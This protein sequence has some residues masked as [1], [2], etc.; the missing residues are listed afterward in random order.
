MIVAD[1]YVAASAGSLLVLYWGTREMAQRL[2]ALGS[3]PEDLGLV[4]RT[5]MAAKNH[6]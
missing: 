2:R 5:D 6:L 3:L 1:T 4:P